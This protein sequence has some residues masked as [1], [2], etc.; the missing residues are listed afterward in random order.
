[1]GM[2]SIPT[3][4]YKHVNQPNI[5]KHLLCISYMDPVGMGLSEQRCHHRWMYRGPTYPYW[6]SLYKP[7][8]VWSNYSDLTRPHLTW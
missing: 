4:N 6:K 3:F 1:M 2:I 7:Y 5:G 8:I